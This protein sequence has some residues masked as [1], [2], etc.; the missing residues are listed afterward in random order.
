MCIL[1]TYMYVSYMQLT[2]QH[3][4]TVLNEVYLSQMQTEFSIV[5]LEANTK[6]QVAISAINSVGLEGVGVTVNVKTISIGSTVHT[7]IY[8]HF[9][10]NELFF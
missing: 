6:Y 10:Y 9:H 3:H 2:V 5:G 7:H 4:N 1:F 8:I